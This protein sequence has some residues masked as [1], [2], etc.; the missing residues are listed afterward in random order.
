MRLQ[1]QIVETVHEIVKLV[2][3]LFLPIGLSLGN[4]DRHADRH[5][6][7][8]DQF[9]I[10]L[11]DRHVESGGGVA[12]EELGEVNLHA[13]VGVYRR[14][15]D[16]G[17]LVFWKDDRVLRADSAAGWTAL[18]AVVLL[19]DKDAFLSIDAVNAE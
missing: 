12:A 14:A 7:V 6:S 18:L 11:G 15:G 19:F 16:G 4:A 10:A 2:A 17:R 5:A 8:G 13:G 1:T 9:T 3:S